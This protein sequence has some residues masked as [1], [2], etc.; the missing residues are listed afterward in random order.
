[1]SAPA[2]VQSGPRAQDAAGAAPDAAK[3]AAPSASSNPR[4]ARPVDAEAAP[5]VFRLST[6]LADLWH[7]VISCFSAEINDGA[8]LAAD[9][10]AQKEGVNGLKRE[11]FRVLTQIKDLASSF[12]Q[13]VYE[14]LEQL[15][16][17]AMRL[18]ELGFKFKFQMPPIALPALEVGVSASNGVQIQAVDPAPAAAV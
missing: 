16:A 17:L 14:R 7:K 1:M 8:E 4:R 13:S 11:G 3:N 10:G 2:A 6:N 18:F 9:I 5:Q 12:A 15:V